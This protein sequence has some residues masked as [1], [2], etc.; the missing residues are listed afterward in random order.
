[1][2]DQELESASVSQDPVTD[3]LHEEHR[4]WLVCHECGQLQSIVPVSEDFELVC[5]NCEHVLHIGRGKWLDKATAFTLTG[6]I[7][8]IVSNC[9]VFISLRVGSFEQ[10]ATILTGV[11]AL[12][13]REQW[14]LCLLVFTTIFLF[15]LLEIIALLY[16]LIPYRLRIR[17][18]G[19]IRVFRWL[20]QAQ[21]W[22][23]MEIFLLAVLVTSVKLQ[24]MAKLTPGV[25]MYAFFA[26]VASLAVA[27]WF[28]DKRNL[29]SWLNSNN[30]FCH[31]DQEIL[32]D[33]EVCEA[34]VGERT[35]DRLGKCP[36]CEARIHK[37]IPFS[38]QKTTAYLIAAAIL[39][40]PANLLPMMS[41][42]TIGGTR[43]DTVMSGVIELLSHG[44][45][46]IATVVFVASVVIPIA[47]LVV[48]GY[49]VVSV[50]YNFLRGTRRRAQL[51]RLTELVGRWSMVD[52]YVVTLLT[53]LVQFGFLG[54]VEPGGAL[55]AFG[56]VVV[57]TMFAA[58][59]FDARLLWD[60]TGRVKVGAPK[61][62]QITH[63]GV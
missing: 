32:Y 61:K 6:L 54:K 21:P 46:A 56:A 17:L 48:M 8:F 33:C 27:Y 36:R 58:M 3:D 60:S 51:Y 12:F 55:L 14:L 63:A 1:M 34:L 13:D 42:K 52:V 41:F 9:F 29:W 15:P 5:T 35:V 50:K 26:L 28:I 4:D 39:Y 53:A 20:M 18:P 19:Q 38:L 31:D 10:E 40:I 47:K 59:S 43:S 24:D 25:S 22:S 37:R 7:L 62:S 57:L 49:L 44:M 2:P 11:V 16:L 30:C 45:W 23:M